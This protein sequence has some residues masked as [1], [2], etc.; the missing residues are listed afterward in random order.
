MSD[1]GRDVVRSLFA[2]GFLFGLMFTVGGVALLEWKLA[3]LAALLAGG[4]GLALRALSDPK[5]AH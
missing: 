3:A 5:P 2:A 1:L 4:S